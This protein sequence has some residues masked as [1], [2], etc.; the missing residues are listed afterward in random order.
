MPQIEASLLYGF[1]HHTKYNKSTTPHP[2]SAPSLRD[3][4]VMHVGGHATEE[5][6]SL[7]FPGLLLPHIKSIPFYLF[8]LSPLFYVSMR[9]LSISTPPP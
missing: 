6:F 1:S 7:M 8:I 5:A 2:S 4:A 3:G 9:L